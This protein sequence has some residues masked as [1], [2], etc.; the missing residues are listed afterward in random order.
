MKIKVLGI[1]SSPIKNG[2]T[3]AFLDVAV[4]AAEEEGDVETEVIKLYGKVGQ[5]LR[6]CNHCNWCVTKQ[7]QEGKICQYE[8]EDIMGEIYR[9][10]LAADGFLF[11]TPVY[12]AKMSGSMANL[13]DRLRAIGHGKVY[14][15]ALDGK[16]G[17]ALAVTWH[18]NAG[19]EAC[20]LTIIHGFMT[21]DI[22]PVGCDLTCQ[23][24]AAGVS[25]FGGTG[26]F[27]TSDKLLVLKDEWGI[28]NARMLAKRFV[29]LTRTI[30]AGR[31]ALGGPKDRVAEPAGSL[32]GPGPN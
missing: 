9:K 14:R 12:D 13:F 11:A 31:M 30:K 22:T 16:V 20:L 7:S 6:G 17:G 8:D 18:R 24:G 15:E 1:C 26:K 23:F 27:D 2:N 21:W 32:M 29:K 19:I 3:A 10:M 25:S 4:K 5:T 28:K